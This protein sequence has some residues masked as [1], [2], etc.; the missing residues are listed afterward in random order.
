VIS[1][2]R[3]AMGLGLAAAAMSV[4]GCASAHAAT[5]VP[6]AAGASDVPA[7]WTTVSTPDANALAFRCALSGGILSVT[8]WNISAVQEQAWH[9]VVPM[10]DGGQQIGTLDDGDYDIGDNEV[11]PQQKMTF[12][13]QV[14]GPATSCQVTGND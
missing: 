13:E 8:V 1:K 14:T 6:S 3:A 2:A 7:G 5:P 11:Q 9:L 4:A 10:F 12:T